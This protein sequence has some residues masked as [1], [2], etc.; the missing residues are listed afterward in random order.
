MQRIQLVLPSS[1]QRKQ[2]AEYKR[3]VMKN[4]NTVG[5]GRLRKLETDEWIA[6]CKNVREGISLPENYVPATQFLAIRTSDNK[7]VGLIQIRHKLNPFLLEYCG[8]IGYNVTPEERGNGYATEM[9]ALALK[10]CKKLG[11]GRVMVS[12]ADY[13]KA[14]ARVIQKNGGVFDSETEYNGTILHRYWI[15]V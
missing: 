5:C 11:L 10:H 4:E 13:N 1:E 8:H 7:L 2:I 12:C 6:F 3:K 14:S 15:D 9:L